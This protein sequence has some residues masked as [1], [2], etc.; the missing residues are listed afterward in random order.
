MKHRLGNFFSLLLI[1]S[2]FIQ[3]GDQ[4]VPT[5]ISD[6]SN[7]TLDKVT[8]VEYSFDY[9]LSLDPPYTDC[10]TG[11]PMQNYGIVKVYVKEKTTPS[12][13]WIATGYTDYNAYGGVTLVNTSTMEIWTLQ[14]GQNPFHEIANHNGSY[15]LHY[16]WNELYKLNNQNLNIHLKGFFT[17]DK[18]GNIT[19]ELETYSCN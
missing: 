9:D 13:N 1:G 4:Q 3:C 16:H 2:L 10:V 6:E 5:A 7:T 17:I 11:A 8:V 19:K 15:R 14:N 18:N 12:G